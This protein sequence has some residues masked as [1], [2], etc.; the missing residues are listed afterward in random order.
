MKNFFKNYFILSLLILGA[1]FS[2]SYNQDT[3]LFNKCVFPIIDNID[4]AW[5]KTDLNGHLKGD[6]ISGYEIWGRNHDG[7]DFQITTVS[8]YVYFQKQLF[9]AEIS[10]GQG[11]DDYGNEEQ[12]VMKEIRTSN[13]PCKFNTICFLADLPDSLQTIIYYVLDSNKVVIRKDTL[14]SELG[15]SGGTERSLYQIPIPELILAGNSTYHIGFYQSETDYG[16]ATFV[17]NPLYNADVSLDSTYWYQDLTGDPAP[18]IGDTIVRE[19]VDVITFN[20]EL[21]YR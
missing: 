2:V 17:T 3:K 8:P 10:L 20:F 14:L 13:D 5:A 15:T 6:S 9:T 4:K 19:Y 11:V 1:V 16:F 21:V 18:D 7:T 12:M